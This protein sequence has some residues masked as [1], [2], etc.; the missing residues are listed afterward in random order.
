MLKIYNKIKNEKFRFPVFV[1]TPS[2]ILILDATVCLVIGKRLL[3]GMTAYMLRLAWD[4][5][6]VFYFFRHCQKSWKRKWYH[7]INQ[8]CL[9]LLVVLFSL[10][11]N[12]SLDRLRRFPRLWIFFIIH[13]NQ[14]Y[15]QTYHSDAW[16]K[17]YSRV[18][19]LFTLTLFPYVPHFSDMA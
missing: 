3:H 19:C 7:K 5:F 6:L 11:W 2:K 9:C 14:Y 13:I 17:Q 16:R 8:N 18:N 1:L 10:L 15:K 12:D 4:H